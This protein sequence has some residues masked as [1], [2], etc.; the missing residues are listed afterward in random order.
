M[1]NHFSLMQ[2]AGTFLFLAMLSNLLLLNVVVWRFSLGQEKNNA[3][4]II[5]S[6]PGQHEF[7]NNNIQNPPKVII[8]PTPTSVPAA[9]T[10]IKSTAR[11]F[12]IPFGGGKNATDDWVDMAG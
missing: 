10:I 7:F 2:S 4:K 1:K 12:Y 5:N 8:S 3:D 9:Q 11:E 6:L